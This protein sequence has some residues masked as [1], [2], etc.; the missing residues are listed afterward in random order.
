MRESTHCVYCGILMNRIVNHPH[1]RTVEHMIPQVSVSFKR[2]NG[3]GDFHVCKKCNAD[4]SR[5]DEVLGVICRMVSEHPVGSIDAVHSFHKALGRK[6]SKFIQAIRSIKPLEVGASITLPLTAREYHR[7]G[8][9]LGKGVH[10]ITTGKL[11][12]PE[13][14]ILVDIVS[15]KEL[16]QIKYEYKQK[17]GSEAFEDLALN[18]KIPNVNKESFLIY[19]DKIREM[20]VCFNKVMMFHIR[21]LDKTYVNQKKCVKALKIMKKKIGK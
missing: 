14:P 5:I 10:Y 6:D 2:T 20:F 3:E 15:Q 9:W 16:N 1:S 7:Y 19:D 12:H 8:S 17:N 18:V 21:I 11:L 4:K 13:Q